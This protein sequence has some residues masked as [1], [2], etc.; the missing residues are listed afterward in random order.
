MSGDLTR[1]TL[2]DGCRGVDM[3]TGQYTSRPGDTITVSTG[4]ADLIRQRAARVR[5]GEQFAFGTRRGR[6]CTP[7]RRVWNAWNA[8][9]PKCGEP[10]EEVD[11][12]EHLQHH[13]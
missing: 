5:H 3:A 2:P 9:C 7:C 6:A 11:G 12:G 10:T 13:R 1:I 8:T 4:N